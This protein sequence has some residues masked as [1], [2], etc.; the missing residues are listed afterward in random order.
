MKNTTLGQVK[1]LKDY[2]PTDWWKN[3]FDHSYLVTTSQRVNEAHTINDVNFLIDML[4]I[5]PDMKVI[6]I[7]CGQGRHIIELIKREF[8]H[9]EG[10]D[11]SEVLLSKL[12]EDLTKHFGINH[13]IKIHHD[14]VRT[15]KIGKNEFDVAYM[16][17]NSLG[18]SD[19][20]DDDRAILRNILS[21]LKPGGKIFLDTNNGDYF[22][23]NLQPKIWSWQKLEDGS[24][25]I[26]L[27]ERE[28]VEDKLAMRVI[29]ISPTIGVIREKFYAIR[30]FTKDLL[31]KL[32]QD[33]GFVD[34][35]I[36]DPNDEKESCNSKVTGSMM[37]HRYLTIATKP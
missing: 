14:D 12:K 17:G 13:Q 16:L 32:L 35:K 25:Y 31:I 8:K 24:E 7:C 5:T 37:D 34:I 27:R 20:I 18:Y 29:L 11:F 4:H 21:I 6:D 23:K 9:V 26:T 33:S 28:L 2:I 10:I 3:Y 19:K 15:M 1:S 30:L 22:M 36:M